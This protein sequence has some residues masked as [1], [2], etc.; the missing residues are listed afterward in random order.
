MDAIERAA[1]ISVGRACGFAGLAILCVLTGLSFE[2]VLAARTGGILT[3][4]MTLFLGYRARVAP[5]R[6]YRATEAW[7]MLAKAERPDDA[8]AQGLIGSALQEAYV[9][10]ARQ[11]AFVSVVLWTAVI[12]LSLAGAE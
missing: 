8:V 11:T 3:F 5:R 4:G 12:V 9:W 1:F 2:P 10:F 7:L 6:P